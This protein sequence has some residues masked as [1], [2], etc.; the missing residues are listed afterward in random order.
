MPGEGGG[1]TRTAGGVRTGGRMAGIGC[2]R[3]PYRFKAPEL[4]HLLAQEPQ[5]E[6]LVVDGGDGDARV[7]LLLVEAVELLEKIYLCT[8]GGFD[9]VEALQAGLE[10]EPLSRRRRCR[11]RGCVSLGYRA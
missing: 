11:R 2:G 8:G 4:V 7:A 6:R 3:K 10:A 1:T 5:I 9:G